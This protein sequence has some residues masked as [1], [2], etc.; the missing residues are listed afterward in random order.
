MPSLKRLYLDEI[1]SSEYSKYPRDAFGHPAL[2]KERLDFCHTPGCV[3]LAMCYLQENEA[4][5]LAL[6]WRRES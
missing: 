4:V 2:M 6:S 5:C 1:F 3:F